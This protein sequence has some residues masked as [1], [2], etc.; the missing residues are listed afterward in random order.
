MKSWLK[1]IEKLWNIYI[2]RL[3]HKSL[4]LPLHHRSTDA[5]VMLR[6]TSQDKNTGNPL[7]CTCPL[8]WCSWNSRKLWQGSSQVSKNLGTARLE[9]E[10]SLGWWTLAESK[11]QFKCQRFQHSWAKSGCRYTLRASK[12]WIFLNMTNWH[13]Q[14]ELKNLRSKTTARVEKHVSGWSAIIT[15]SIQLSSSSSSSSV[16]SHTVF[17]SAFRADID[18]CGKIAAHWAWDR[19]CACFHLW[20]LSLL[21]LLFLFLKSNDD[22]SHYTGQLR[23]VARCV[24]DPTRQDPCTV[25]AQNHE[26][27]DLDWDSAQEFQHLSCPNSEL[28]WLGHQSDQIL[29]WLSKASNVKIQ[30]LRPRWS[31]TTVRRYLENWGPVQ[32][33][34]IMLPVLVLVLWLVQPL[35]RWSCCL[36][37]SSQAHLEV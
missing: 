20:T 22:S 12:R 11:W 25:K 4:Q 13:K 34:V 19:I 35:N 7:H 10:Q 36:Q 33:T 16:L 24:L 5:V 29:S 15:A 9:R 31:H 8:A 3:K 2:W 30:V 1:S 18:S 17:G 21:F 26:V 27:Q 14:S 28:A 37:A 32:R 6:L 23:V